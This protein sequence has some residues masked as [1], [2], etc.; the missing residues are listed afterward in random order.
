MWIVLALFVLVT[1]DDALIPSLIV[2]G[3]ILIGAIYFAW[4]MIFNREVLESEP[5]DDEFA[6]A[7]KAAG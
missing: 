4:M 1:P 6:V 3:L 7:P 5:G 2:I